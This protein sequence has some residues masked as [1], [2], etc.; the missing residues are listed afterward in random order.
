MQPAEVGD[1][2]RG[3][4]R[5]LL[6]ERV[7]GG[8]MAVSGQAVEGADRLVV[9]LHSLDHGRRCQEPALGVAQSVARQAREGAGAAEG[10]VEIAGCAQRQRVA[11]TGG[12][13]H[14]RRRE[15]GGV[16]E[17]VVAEVAQ[18]AGD[19]QTG[20]SPAGELPED[21]AIGVQDR[22]AE[23]RH[24]QGVGSP[25]V[26]IGDEPQRAGDIG[27]TR[28]P[29]EPAG[30][31]P[32]HGFQ[33]AGRR[34]AEIALDAGRNDEVVAVVGARRQ[35]AVVGHVADYG[36]PQ[37]H[38]AVVGRIA[39]HGAEQL[40]A[41]ARLH[42]HVGMQA[43]AGSYAQSAVLDGRAAAEAVVDDRGTE[44]IRLADQGQRAAAALD[45]PV[46]ALS[47]AGQLLVGGAGHIGHHAIGGQRRAAGHGWWGKGRRRGIGA[48][49]A[50]PAAAGG[51]QA[52]RDGKQQGSWWG[53][54]GSHRDSPWRLRGAPCMG[55]D[56]KWAPQWP[57]NSSKTA[58][59]K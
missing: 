9:I 30:N 38:P 46:V 26:G 43:G 18:V 33:G 29:H 5:C 14:L 55:A 12:G 25:S 8:G 48:H 10:A 32:D 15:A 1:Q 17:D 36:V 35:H 49:R 13:H 24:G 57:E 58:E 22:Q 21:A 39:G 50:A 41:A 59:I 40:Q 16:E 23:G 51:Q 7:D 6:Q 34:L 47:S 3:R 53:G 52:A 45:Q 54:S 4:Q 28:D 2:A 11:R 27:P 44:G 37:V 19:E 42:E 31:R 56:A 20:R